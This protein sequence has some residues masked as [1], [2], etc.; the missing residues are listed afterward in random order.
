MVSGADKV[1]MLW[2]ETNEVRMCFPKNRNEVLSGYMCFP[3]N[4]HCGI[5]LS[6][7]II[8][9]CACA[10]ELG[11]YGSVFVCVCVCVCVWV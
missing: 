7:V 4:H 1:T 5:Q 8:P 2:Q 3:K 6:S 9:R 10:S 11:I